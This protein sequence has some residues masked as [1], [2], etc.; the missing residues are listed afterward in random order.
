MRIGI[1]PDGIAERV[2]LDS[3][4]IPTPLMEAFWGMGI[5]RCV[6]AG[7]R[8]CTSGFNELFFYLINGT[9]PYPEEEIRQWRQSAGFSGIRKSRLMFAPEMILMG[10]R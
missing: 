2:L 6:T 10:G 1:I 9:H 5:S 3:G 7:D 8:S 4:V